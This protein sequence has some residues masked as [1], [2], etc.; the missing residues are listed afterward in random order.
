MNIAKT[1]YE[2]LMSEWSSE[3]NFEKRESSSSKTSRPKSGFG[4]RRG[5]NPEQ[6]NGIHRRRRKQIRW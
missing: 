4:R 6:F 1:N 2:E 3:T 5:K